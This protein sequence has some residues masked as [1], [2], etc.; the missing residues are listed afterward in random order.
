MGLV[1]V[2]HVPGGHSYV[3]HTS[4]LP[5][6]ETDGVEP[7]SGEPDGVEPDGVEVVPTPVVPGSPWAS[8]PA[9]E[10][11]WVAANAD[12][13]DVLHV[14][15]G[16]EGRTPQQLRDLV[17]ALHA[18]GR[19]LVVTVHDLQNPHLRDQTAF[20]ELLGIL[21]DGADGLLTLTPGAAAE[22]ERR[23]GRRPVVVPHPHVVPAERFDRPR[24]AHDGFVVGVHLK[25]LR[26]N[27]VATRTLRHLAAVVGE[28]P[29]AVLRVDV[30]REAL[31]PAFVRHDAELARWLQE[32]A[33]PEVRTVDV[34]VH[35]RFTDDELWDHLSALD[36]SVLPYGHG[37]HSGWLEACHDLGTHVVAGPVGYLAEQ[38]PL[39]LVDLDDADSLRSALLRAYSG[40]RAVRAT[41]SE[42]SRQ[43]EAVAQAHRALYREVAATAGDRVAAR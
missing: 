27:L 38:Q 22:V 31:D 37:T 25:S 39:L 17:E 2:L 12:A 6:A 9:L 35:E 14:H 15:F 8:S 11:G 5:P 19:A 20:T 18:H 7:D 36:V 41:W 16:F 26:A 32:V 28:L 34:R 40:G 13:F 3:E 24:P 42:R 33:A 10:P 30:H 1:R 4:A 29:G 23:W 21:V 43:R